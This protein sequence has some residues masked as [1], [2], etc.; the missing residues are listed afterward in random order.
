MKTW[1]KRS[2]IAL[3]ILVVFGVSLIFGVNLYV[4]RTSS[5]YILSPTE[6][7]KADAVLVL[8][9]HVFSDGKVSDM[10]N[11]R[12]IEAQELYKLGKADKILVSGDHGQ[13][14]YDEVNAMKDFLVER[15]VPTQ[16]IFMDHAGFSTYE[17]MYRARDVFEIKKVIIVTQGYHLMRAVFDAREL[18]LEAYGVAS[19]L[20]NYGPVMNSYRLREIAARDKDFFFAKLFKP[21]P[22][23]LGK[24]IPITGDGRATDDK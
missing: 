24:T 18:G 7:P 1:L 3:G 21:L 5:R 12:L 2:L 14:D 20:R 6:A 9:A 4:E 22:T 11:D 17:S 13:K 19:D 16:D 8:G 23:F 10:L 15:G